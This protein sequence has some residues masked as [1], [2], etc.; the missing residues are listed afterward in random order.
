MYK[1]NVGDN[2]ENQIDFTTSGIQVNGQWIGWDMITTGNRRFHVIMNNGSY[3]CEVVSADSRK[4]SFEIKV[5]GVVHR[6]NVKDQFDELLHQLGMDKIASH[7]VNDIKAP[8]PGLVLK[9]MI[10][11]KQEIKEGDSVL[12]LEA[13]KMENVI[14]SPGA[15]IVKSIKVKE[16]DAV[17]KN[18]V[19]IELE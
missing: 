16:R 15:G 1:V 13:M 5:N 14:K 10:A 2:E 8:M 4:K 6:V 19:L 9:I 18:E 17:E 7:K 12:I 11:E 3:N